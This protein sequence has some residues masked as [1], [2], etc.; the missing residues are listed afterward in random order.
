M[1]S[2]RSAYRNLSESEHLP[3]QLRAF[4]W[5]ATCGQK[6]WDAVL[7]HDGAGKVVAA[8]PYH[9]EHKWGLR[10]LRAAPWA[11]YGGMYLRKP[12]SDRLYR[13]QAFEQQLSRRLMEHLPAADV[14]HFNFHPFWQE[15]AAFRQMGAQVLCRTTYVFDAGM[16][17]ATIHR[18]MAP[19][20]RNHLRKA[21][22]EGVL[23]NRGGDVAGFCSLLVQRLGRKVVQSFGGCAALQRLY[24]GLLEQQ[25]GLLLEARDDALG[26]LLAAC[27]LVWD[28]QCLHFL[29]SA[30]SKRGRQS[31]SMYLL[32]WEAIKLAA[33]KKLAFDFNGSILPG[34]E[35]VFRN[36][37]ARRQ[38]YLEL[39]WGRSLKGSLGV[40]AFCARR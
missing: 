1:A 25:A 13:Q 27:L 21:R 34:V 37:G 38:A 18:Q 19:A 32:I 4:W 22:R 29:L 17:A 26:E 12:P 7:L 30:Q 11:T 36:F 24:A 5:D 28:D 23:I 3:V 9:L 10:F 15:V 33:R 14:V 8:M 16:D 35:P 39:L 40:W 31:R 2:N 6:D 20:A